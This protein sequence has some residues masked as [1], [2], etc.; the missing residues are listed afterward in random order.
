M[1]LNAKTTGLTSFFSSA[2]VMLLAATTVSAQDKVTFDDD[3]QPISRQKCFS[4]HNQNKKSSGL[5]LTTYTNLMLG[6]SS[7]DVLEPGSPDDSYLF[8]LITHQSEPF[9]PPKSQKMPDA[10]ISLIQK[11]IE[12]GMP[13]NAGSKIMVPKKKKFEFNP[14]PLPPRLW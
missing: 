3:I 5:D 11:W 7:G 14:Y 4:C 10:E 12:Q 1:R 6:G 13:E 2:L 8:L 9:M